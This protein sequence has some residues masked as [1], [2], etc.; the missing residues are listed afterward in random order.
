MESL[1]FE[2]SVCVRD[3]V[4]GIRRIMGLEQNV[5]QRNKG[6]CR[7]HQQKVSADEPSL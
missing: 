6:T 5:D 2:G 3:W 1:A 7:R 4:T